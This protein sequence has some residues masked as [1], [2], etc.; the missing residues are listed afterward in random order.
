MCICLVNLA[1]NRGGA[2]IFALAFYTGVEVEG[3][4]ITEY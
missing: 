4:I 3:E 1:A 2:V